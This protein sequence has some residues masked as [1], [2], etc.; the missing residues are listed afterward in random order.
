MRIEEKPEGYKTKKRTCEV[1]EKHL[2]RFRL[3]RSVRKI[4]NLYLEILNK[5]IFFYLQENYNKFSNLSKEFD[6]YQNREKSYRSLRSYLVLL[7][8]G[9]V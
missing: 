8:F 7:I 9:L 3:G 6:F 4:I 1:V 2:K 5:K